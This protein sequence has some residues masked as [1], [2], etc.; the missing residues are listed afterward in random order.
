MHYHKGAQI[1]VCISSNGLF[2][3]ELVNLNIL[4]SFTNDY[5]YC[6]Y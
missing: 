1:D 2:V 6:Q 3:I 5:V 4:S